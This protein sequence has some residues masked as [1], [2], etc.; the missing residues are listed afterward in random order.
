LQVVEVVEALQVDPQ[1]V[2][3][4]AALDLFQIYLHVEALLMPTL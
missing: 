4:L 1:A 3:E 2:V